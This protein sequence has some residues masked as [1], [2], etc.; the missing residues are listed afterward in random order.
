M[1]GPKCKHE[2]PKYLCNTCEPDQEI[3]LQRRVLELEC[4]LNSTKEAL[5]TALNAIPNAD[6]AQNMEDMLE[7]LKAWAC[8]CGDSITIYGRNCCLACEARDILQE[9]V[10]S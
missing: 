1:A 10:K 7:D 3:V 4:E 8:Y 6:R 9:R 2:I 5:N